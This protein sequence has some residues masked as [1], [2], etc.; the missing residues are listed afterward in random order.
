MHRT[1]AVIAVGLVVPIGQF[2]V[3]G[4]GQYYPQPPNAH[5]QQAEAERPPEKDAPTA[6][7]RAWLRE[8]MLREF[9]GT[10]RSS[11]V[12]YAIAGMPPERIDRLVE[13]YKK[14]PA[15]YEEEM[16]AESR[17]RLAQTKAYRDYLARVYQAR[18]A[19]AGRRSVGY[20]PVIVTLPEGASLAAS[21]IVSP[22][23]RYVRITASPFF[24]GI[25]G[26]RTFSTG[27][28]RHR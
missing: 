4:E 17:A 1:M 8:Q 2:A 21:A 28:R 10:G 19:A 7:K 11:E 24:S 14:R 6:V 3:S 9:R 23:R 5:A 15:W 22:D 26:M 25:T 20:A 18:R 13:V 27:S 16:L 12:E